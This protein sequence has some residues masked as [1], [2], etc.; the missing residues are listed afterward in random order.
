MSKERKHRKIL[1]LNNGA[2]YP[3]KREDSRYYYCADTQF[4]KSNQDIVLIEKVTEPEMD[5]EE[6]YAES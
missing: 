5:K 6:K 3:V 1:Y 2:V 4:R